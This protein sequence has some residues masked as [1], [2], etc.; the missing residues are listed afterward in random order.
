[1]KQSAF[2]FM[3]SLDFSS[4]FFSPPFSFYEFGSTEEGFSLVWKAELEFFKLVL[5]LKRNTLLP[6]LISLVHE[7]ETAVSG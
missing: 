6:A 5:G 1:M 2:L 7:V 3:S 4:S